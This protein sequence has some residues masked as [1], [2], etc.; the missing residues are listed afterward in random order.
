M[1]PGSESGLP[2]DPTAASTRPIRL[3]SLQVPAAAAATAHSDTPVSRPTSPGGSDAL[4]VRSSWLR[5][6]LEKPIDI[7]ELAPACVGL[8]E[9]TPAGSNGRTSGH[10][11]PLP[12]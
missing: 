4:N 12:S 7:V 5:S 6:G 9:T 11:A 3:S 8:V 2:P 1:E 10:G